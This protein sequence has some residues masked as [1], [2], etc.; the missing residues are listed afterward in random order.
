MYSGFFVQQ[1]AMAPS[2]SWLPYL[3]PTR[4]LL[5]GSL[6][7]HFDGESF[8]DTSSG[9]LVSG[10]DVLRSV[11]DIREGNPWVSILIGLGFWLLMRGQHLMLM[12]WH[13]RKLGSAKQA[14]TSSPAGKRPA[15]DTN[16]QET[17]VV[18]ITMI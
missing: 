17:E 18:S 1:S 6:A 5:R 9:V 16:P 14:T 12:W 3:M 8:L 2:I 4:Y 7:M 13:L 15:A 10:K 11:F